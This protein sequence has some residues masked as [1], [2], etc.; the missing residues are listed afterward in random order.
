MK[1]IIIILFLFVGTGCYCLQCEPKPSSAEPNFEFDKG[2]F[3]DL[4]HTDNYYAYKSTTKEDY[5]I[6]ENCG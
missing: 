6:K 2:R 3:F 1:K 5:I 4:L